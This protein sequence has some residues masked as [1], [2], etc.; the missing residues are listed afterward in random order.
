MSARIK[1]R[2]VFLIFVT[3]NLFSIT[4]FASAWPVFLPP[5]KALLLDQNAIDTSRC[6]PGEGRL[7]ASFSINIHQ[8]LCKTFCPDSWTWIAKSDETCHKLATDFT[9][10]RYEIDHYHDQ[11]GMTSYSIVTASFGKKEDAQSAFKFIFITP[12][13]HWYCYEMNSDLHLV[14]CANDT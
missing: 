7:I 5:D 13:E 6:P 8:S 4:T 9:F 1:N 12:E 2:F 10:Q 11:D 3:L 14:S